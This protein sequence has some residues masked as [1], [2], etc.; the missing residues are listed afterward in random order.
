[1]ISYLRK[2]KCFIEHVHGV[3]KILSFAFASVYFIHPFNTMPDAFFVSKKT[4]KRKRTTSTKEASSSKK[5]IN[6]KG[7]PEPKSGSK[8]RRRDEELESDATGDDDIGGIDDLELRVSDSDP[9]AS[10]DEDELETPAEKRLRLAKVYLESVK[11]GLGTLHRIVL[12][13]IAYSW[14]LSHGRG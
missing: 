13:S 14:S 3:C 12:H 11:E 5:N 6:G 9:N 7:R 2:Y 1:M 10:A 8:A 4:R